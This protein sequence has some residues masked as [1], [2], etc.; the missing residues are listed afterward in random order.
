MYMFLISNI[1]KQ[2]AQPPFVRSVSPRI[3]SSTIITFGAASLRCFGRR[4]SAVFWA[5]LLSGVLGAASQRCFGRRFSAVFWAPLLCGVSGA[6]RR[7]VS[8]YLPPK[9]LTSLTAVDPTS[10]QLHLRLSTTVYIKLYNSNYT[11]VCYI[12]SCIIRF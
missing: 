8:L 11:A 9:A 6:A 12:A 4:F 2:Q 7:T 3:H 1:L 10:A 5:P